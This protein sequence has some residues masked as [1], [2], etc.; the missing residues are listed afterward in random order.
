MHLN[1]MAWAIPL[2]LLL[3]GIEY[4]VARKKGWKYFSFST[5]IS[6]L[7]VGVAERLLD[8][9][10]IGI[11]YFVYDYLHRHFAIFNIQ[12]SV[13]LWIALLI[14]TDFIWYWYHRLAHEVNILWGAHVVHHQ[15]EDFNYTVS[16]R[17][18]VFQA[19]ARMMFW[20][21]LPVIGFPPAMIISVQLVHGLYPFFIHTRTIGKLGVLEYIF[22]TPSHHRVHHACN[23]QYLDKNYGDVL[24][25][26]D[27]LFG[28]FITE[29]E[30]PEYGLTKPLDSHSFLWQHF[31]FLLEIAYAFRQAKGLKQKWLVVFGKPDHINP[32]IR[33]VLEEK[34][35]FRNPTGT[36]TRR[37]HNY[38]VAQMAMTLAALFF[39]LLLEKYI[40]LFVQACF[41]VFIF[42][43]LINSGAILEQ[44]QWV[45]YLE[46]ARLLV[47]FLAV[48]YCWP[49]P[50]LLWLIALVQTLVFYYKA[51]IQQRYLR[52]LYGITT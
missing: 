47:I 27:K 33:E 19:F 29:Q 52:L 28:T 7:N 49:R 8:T 45:F 17:I 1:H 23:E 32:G 40:P 16:A 11:F 9:F 43:T 51:T 4:G 38:V 15:S 50:G 35:L 41:T 13:L 22:V 31:H 36:T 3:M 5:S 2:F 20:S 24:I 42:L 30:E 44:R 34:F 18:T 21:V 10:T 26:W 46:Y 12:S 14:M 39:F 25:I 48:Y 37:L 6:N